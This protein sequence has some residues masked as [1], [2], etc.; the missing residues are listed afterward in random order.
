MIT[1]SVSPTSLP[2]NGGDIGIK[3]TT[4]IPST[5]AS[6]AVAVVFINGV[7]TFVGQELSGST[8]SQ[9]YSIFPNTGIATETVE[10]QI[11]IEVSNVM[12]MSNTVDVTV[13]GLPLTAKT[14]VI[15]ITPTSLSASGGKVT[16]NGSTRNIPAGA[17]VNISAA[18]YYG[19]I[20]ANIYKLPLNS[21]G[22]FSASFDVPANLDFSSE[23]I[24]IQAY[25]YLPSGGGPI[26]SNII[27]MVVA[28][29]TAP[30]NTLI[31]VSPTTELRPSGGTIDIRGMISTNPAN[32]PCP[33]SCSGPFYPGESSSGCSECFNSFGGDISILI[34]G[35]TVATQSGLIANTFF[36]ALLVSPNT[37][38][39]AETLDVQVATTL[40][41]ITL[42]S[43][44]VTVE[45]AAA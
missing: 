18:V 23:T 41:N 44:V 34:N 22:T 31:T 8:F 29:S 10:V 24:G 21:D 26:S 20:L 17:T 2:S 7:E 3:G 16:V 32:P 45:V 15:S 4:T 42:K 5:A 36:Q 27:N 12:V 9:P 28:G 13:A 25:A 14:C 1:I 35:K 11:G 6:R 37:G 40:N 33:R 39:S 38:T 30:F 43:N 19:A